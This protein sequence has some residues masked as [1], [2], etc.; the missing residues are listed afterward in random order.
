MKFLGFSP[1]IYGNTLENLVTI[2]FLRRTEKKEQKQAYLHTSHKW[3]HYS[4]VAGEKISI[5]HRPSFVT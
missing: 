3:T 2:S 4:G 1:S 5:A